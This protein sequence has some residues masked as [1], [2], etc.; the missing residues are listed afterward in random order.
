VLYQNSLLA[1]VF[2]ERNALSL[3]L[4]LVS[5]TKIALTILNALFCHFSAA[6]SRQQAK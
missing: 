1:L 2:T 6:I 4:I 3:V 5:V